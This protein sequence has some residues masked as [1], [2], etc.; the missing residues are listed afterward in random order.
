[1]ARFIW[2]RCSANPSSQRAECSAIT[3]LGDG[4]WKGRDCTRLNS[5]GGAG[6][7]NETS[8]APSKLN[9]TRQ[10][11]RFHLTIILHDIARSEGGKTNNGGC[12][13][14]TLFPRDDRSARKLYRSRNKKEGKKD[15]SKEN[16]N[17]VNFKIA[18]N[19]AAFFRYAPL[20]ASLKQKPF[21]STD[22]KKVF[23]KFMRYLAVIRREGI[24]RSIRSSIIN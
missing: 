14:A 9:A 12:S 4:R 18:I 22:F 6:E 21:V 15:G 7:P 11:P 10:R 3:V 24:S 2:R 16:G 13:R 8:V 1:M 23:R 5:G 20:F 19:L 17:S